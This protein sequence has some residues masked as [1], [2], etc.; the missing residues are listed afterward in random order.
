MGGTQNQINLTEHMKK[1]FEDYFSD[2]PKEKVSITTERYDVLLS[3]PTDET[4]IELFE[5]NNKLNEFT[6][7][8]DDKYPEAKYRGF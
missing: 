6:L 2:L 8:E 7:I 4:K 5:E 1:Q 3:Y